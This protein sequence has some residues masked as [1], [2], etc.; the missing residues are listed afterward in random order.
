MQALLTALQFL[1]RLPVP[2]PRK[3]DDALIG[4]SGLHYPLVG[5]VIGGL[6]ALALGLLLA[7]AP[8][9]ATQAPGV[10][11][12]LLL[13]L[14]VGLT[15]GLHLDGLADS[16]DGWLSGAGP[17]RCLAIMRDPRAGSGAVIAVVLVLIAKFT[18]LQHLLARGPDIALWF[19]LVAVPAIGRG[20]ALGL[21]LTTP[22][23]R[24][25]GLTQALDEHLPRGPAWA[26]LCGLALLVIAVLGMAGVGLLVAV[27]L[28]VWLLRALMLRRIGGCTGDTAG[29]VIEFS[30]LVALLALGLAI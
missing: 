23:A 5:I 1:T 24:R 12:A 29:A 21:L 17:E 7:L 25:G 6:L 9:P 3:L 11:A 4:R 14:W 30:E 10:Y 27:G 8:A 22:G 15:G 26:I 16:A 28:C 13:M 19:A 20:A 2:G 18:A